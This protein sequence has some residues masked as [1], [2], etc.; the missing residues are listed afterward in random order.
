MKPLYYTPL[1]PARLTGVARVLFVAF[2]VASPAKPAAA[3][4]Y[5]PG[6]EWMEFDTQHYRVVYPAEIESEARRVARILEDA[7]PSTSSSMDV[8][9]RR[10]PIVLNNRSATS[11]GFVAFGP[12]RSVWESTPFRPGI[13]DN[14]GTADWY[15]LLAVHELRHVAQIT[16]MNRGMSRLARIGFGDRGL[17]TAIAL[18]VP[19]WFTE[20]DAVVTETI[21]TRSG[22]G[23]NPS[24]D[25]HFRAL[26]MEG[27]M[28]GYPKAR[29]RSYR[30]FVPGHYPY[31]YLVTSHIAREYGQGALGDIAGRTGAWSFVPLAF[32]LAV[33]SVTGRGLHTLHRETMADLDLAW[34][35]QRQGLSYTPATRR[36]DEMK[37][38]W[39]NYAH[40]HYVSDRSIITVQSGLREAADLVVLAPYRKPERLGRVD[41]NMYFD[42]FDANADFAVWAQERPHALFGWLGYSVI[43]R[44]DHV[45]G[46]TRA[47]TD[48]TRLFNPAIS[49]DRALVAA[50]EF[51]SV[52]RSWIV[53]VDA[54]T[55]RQVF[56]V[57]VP[58]NRYAGE[59][60]WTR[61]GNAILVLVTD[62]SGK[63]ILELRLGDYTWRTVAP[64]ALDNIWALADG[65]RYVYFVSDVSGIDNIYAH[66]RETG[67]RYRVTSRPLGAYFPAISPDGERIAFSDYTVD[68]FDVVEAPLDPAAWTPVD[69]VVA[70]PLPALALGLDP[71]VGSVDGSVGRPGA[72]LHSGRI[73][74]A[75]SARA[76]PYRRARDLFWFHSWQPF[77]DGRTAGLSIEADNLL[78]TTSI[79]I[80]GFFD[81]EERAFVSA[82]TTTVSRWYPIVTLDGRHGGRSGSATFPDGSTETYS[83]ME[84]GGR[85]SLGFPARFDRGRRTTSFNA[86][87][88]G[89]W[90]RI[91]DR[92][93]VPFLGHG[94]GHLAYGGFRFVFANTHAAAYADFEPPG[95]QR[96][97]IGI[98][99]ATGRS[100]Y[101][102]RHGFLSSLFVFRGLAP[103]HRIRFRADAE[104]QRPENYRFSSSIRYARGN[105]YRYADN[106]VRAT[107]EYTFPAAYPDLAIGNL[108]YVP[109]ILGNV[110][111]D[112][113]EAGAEG[114]TFSASGR[115]QS[116]GIE[117]IV[118]FYVFSFPIPIRA[119]G[120]AVYRIEQGDYKFE[121]VIF[122]IAF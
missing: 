115:F 19:A 94:N 110:F 6:I 27:R 32:P 82:A 7:Y 86:T 117:A 57:A 119:G 118:E 63:S 12:R 52:R 17:A 65:G 98:D 59:V 51:D 111:Y 22:R 95:V 53:V 114:S 44:R 62:G 30:D 2:L 93:Y 4:R 20:G 99:A 70:E 87:I 80:G 29:F 25:K 122:A 101:K 100:D 45:S 112:Y 8:R 39:T 120:R 18:G 88:N 103:Q 23:R 41:P 11:N 10:I 90:F 96:V 35:Y 3:Q 83:W 55:G 102:S 71:G 28:Y 108:L 67:R 109:R 92:E 58:D 15:T 75:D 54:S 77:Y 105:S 9:P 73:V 42:G 72:A 81:F 113:S 33:R 50:V 74:G 61:G 43:M 24:F 49:P 97:V 64:P 34:R 47:L 46:D 38:R 91:A 116:V 21:L 16:R 14:L 106:L 84:T 79:A 85:F 66:D 26:L 78:R 37:R 76:R 13:D 5:P 68:G 89:G 107:I 60:E 69:S 36:N 48:R 56:R 121:P 40:P 104:A 31:G 1:A